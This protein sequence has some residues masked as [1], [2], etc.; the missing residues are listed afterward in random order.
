MDRYCNSR[1][2]DYFD[3]WVKEDEPYWDDN[4]IPELDDKYDDDILN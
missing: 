2:D 3:P 4:Y 1:D